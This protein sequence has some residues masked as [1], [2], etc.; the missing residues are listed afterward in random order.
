MKTIKLL[1]R[2]IRLG[3]V[4]RWYI[5]ILPVIFAL[6]QVWQC[7]N[8]ID[9][10]KNAE[11]LYSDVTVMDYYLYSMQGMMIFNFDAREYFNIPIYWFLFQIGISY[12]VAYYAHEDF[13]KNGRALFIA[14]KNR[15]AWWRSKCLWCIGSVLLY[16]LITIFTITLAAMY[17]GAKLSLDFTYDFVAGVFSPNMAYLSSKDAVFIAGLLPLGMTLSVCLLQL[18]VGFLLSPVVSFALVCAE[19]VLSAY[20]TSC[21]FVGNYTM[22]LRSSYVF[23]DGL[24][25]LGGVFILLFVIALAYLLGEVYFQKKD[26]M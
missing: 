2:D 4:N 10:L 7:N 22:W 5:L 9:Y 3:I 20:Y 26:V 18:L 25:P 17:F 8:L 14:S 11:V 24:A 16:F 6:A 23:E 12:F 1:K 15:M 13:V 19:Y 21:Y